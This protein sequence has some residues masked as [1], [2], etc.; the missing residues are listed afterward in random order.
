MGVFIGNDQFCNVSTR[1]PQLAISTIAESNI[2]KQCP[3]SLF[4][5]SAASTITTGSEAM[6]ISKYLEHNLFFH[7][8]LPSLKM[9]TEA[10][11]TGYGTSKDVL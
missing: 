6:E 4:A 10:S 5:Y 11:S 3:R 7:P 1:V 9:W 2:S 8:I